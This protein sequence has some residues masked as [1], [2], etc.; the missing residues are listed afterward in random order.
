MAATVPRVCWAWSTIPSRSAPLLLA[1]AAATGLARSTRLFSAVFCWLR[2]S[3]N[4]S[5]RRSA[6]S[7]AASAS[8]RFLPL[9]VTPVPSVVTIAANAVEVGSS[10]E[11]RT[12]SRSTDEAV[13]ASGITPPS[14]ASGAVSA[15]ASRST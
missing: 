11:S 3:T 4:L 5:V 15:P 13:R 14:G 12:W 10:S 2:M 7:T 9:P 6:G 1:T 8:R